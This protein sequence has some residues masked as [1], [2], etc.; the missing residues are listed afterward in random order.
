MEEVLTRPIE[1][2]YLREENDKLENTV[3]HLLVVVSNQ[4]WKTIRKQG[5]EK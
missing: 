4:D 5:R 3:T 1:P 2:L